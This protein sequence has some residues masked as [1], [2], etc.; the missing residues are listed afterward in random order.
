M[1][2]VDDKLKDALE[3][4][5]TSNIQLGR[6]VLT[7][8]WSSYMTFFSN[9]LTYCHKFMNHSKNYVDTIEGTHT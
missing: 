8:Q 2:T 7:D 6:T 5:I 9:Q 1:D 3:R 4:E